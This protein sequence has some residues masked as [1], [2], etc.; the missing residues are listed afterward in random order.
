MN[1]L[2]LMMGGSGTRLGSDIPKQYLEVDQKPVFYY[3]AQEYARMNEIS[4]ISIVSHPLWVEYTEQAISDLCFS[5]TIRVVSGGDTRSASVR[6]GL[7][8]IQDVASEQDVVLIHDATHPYVDRDGVRKIIEAVKLYGGATLGEYQY[9]T[10]Y[11]MGE[12]G[13][14][15]KVF[16]RQLF[17]AGAS[18]EAFR[19]RDISDIYFRANDEELARMTS[20]GAIALSYHIP[21]KVIP[22]NVLNLKITYAED[23]KLFKLLAHDYFFKSDDVKEN[24]NEEPIA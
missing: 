16:P 13:F 4:A 15:E 10:C 19:F 18:P 5:G 1:I 11:R 3:I 20:A 21:M 9:D 8:A 6:N 7:A 14:L 17:V 24:E 23:M 12:D 2:L 22:I